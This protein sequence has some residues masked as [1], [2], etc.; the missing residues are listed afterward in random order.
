MG[1]FTNDQTCD[2]ACCCSQ[3][4]KKKVK[5]VIWYAEK[6]SMPS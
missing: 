2:Y 5:K 1:G 6:F 3:P 4:Q